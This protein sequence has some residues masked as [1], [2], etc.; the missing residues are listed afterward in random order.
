MW[1]SSILSPSE[2][3]TEGLYTVHHPPAQP[4]PCIRP[5][6]P[7][8]PTRLPGQRAQAPPSLAWPWQYHT[9]FTRSPPL[10][11]RPSL[12]ADGVVTYSK[13]AALLRMLEEFLE[14]QQPGSFQAGVRV[15]TR[16]VRLLRLLRAMP[17]SGA[18]HT[19]RWHHA[20]LCSLPLPCLL[21]SRHHLLS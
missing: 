5:L 18:A 11:A 10:C 8:L 4:H 12:P 16:G 14:R 21:C 19:I 13:G 2:C 9:P 20:P 1:Y 7:L 6:C 3:L 15:S 17:A